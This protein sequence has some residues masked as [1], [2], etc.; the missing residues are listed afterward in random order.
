MFG[1]LGPTRNGATNMMGG[2]DPTRR[3]RHRTLHTPH[4]HRPTP[5]SCR[6]ANK[7]HLPD[8]ANKSKAGG[9][10]ESMGQPPQQKAHGHHARSRKL[11]APH[12]ELRPTA[13]EPN[14]GVD[15]VRRALRL[16][17]VVR[18]PPL[19]RKEELAHRLGGVSANGWC[20]KCVERSCLTTPQ[21]HANR[22]D[23]GT[24]LVNA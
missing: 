5:A 22:P 8:A 18:Q 6:V 9:R 12:V 16:A 19:C 20:P 14:E 17:V 15:Q 7:L 24:Q 1:K 2:A 3:T 10:T 4:R 11:S 13:P 21:A 23:T